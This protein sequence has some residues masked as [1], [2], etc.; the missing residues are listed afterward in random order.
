MGANIY[1]VSEPK[2]L[3]LP[4]FFG[5]RVILLNFVQSLDYFRFKMSIVLTYISN[6]YYRNIK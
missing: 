6:T 4:S 2:G 3:C 5:K 1:S